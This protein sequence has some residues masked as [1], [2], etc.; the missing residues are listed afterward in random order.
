MGHFFEK[1]FKNAS[2]CNRVVSTG[3]YFCDA[4]PLMGQINF[5]ESD[6]N[7]SFFTW[8]VIIPLEGQP[9]DRKN[10]SKYEYRGETCYVLQILRSAI[11]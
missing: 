11:T 2:S 3:P 10:D 5:Q 8:H 9:L 4:C 1:K 6:K 7:Q